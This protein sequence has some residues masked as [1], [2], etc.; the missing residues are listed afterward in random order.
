M[1]QHE[2]LPVMAFDIG[3]TWTRSGVY[4]VN[5]LVTNELR[6]RT[7]SHTTSH[8]SQTAI[9]DNLINQISE[10]IEARHSELETPFENVAISFGGALNA[11][12]GE[13][14]NAGP[15]W[16]KNCGSK[17]ELQKILSSRLPHFKWKIVN[18][19][20]AHLMWYV[21]NYSRINYGKTLLITISSGIGC[22]IYDHTTKS[23]PVDAAL[24]IQG[25][26]G[27]VPISF[28]LN[29]APYHS[30]CDCG[31]R[32][33][34]NA[35]CS[36]NALERNWKDY[37]NSIPS[38]NLSKSPND[39]EPAAVMLKKLLQNSSTEGQTILSCLTTPV[40]QALQN[41]L[42]MDP[43]INEVVFTG[44]LFHTLSPFYMDSM[45]AQFEQMGHYIVDDFDSARLR[46]LFIASPE[47]S[48]AGIKGAAEFSLEDRHCHQA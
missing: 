24:G 39:L 22:R 34:L 3:G 15:I 44:G 6:T 7:V 16:G 2:E 47:D 36:G 23:I 38:S 9:Q 13:V 29:G 46:S 31:G 19:I 4:H 40:A 32:D 42:T 27:H 25:E 41:I 17:L 35:F 26:I 48:L 8:L 30:L 18:D 10:I 43:A 21:R 20:S 37:L 1:L 28:I 11:H 45:Y 5:G 33:H 14:Y 12:N